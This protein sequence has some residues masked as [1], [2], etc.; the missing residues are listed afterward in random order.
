MKT[1]RTKMIAGLAIALFLSIAVIG[2]VVLSGG[3][4]TP[5]KDVPDGEWIGILNSATSVRTSYLDNKILTIDSSMEHSPLVTVSASSAAVRKMGSGMAY[6]P[7]IITDEEDDA[8]DRY[9]SLSE[10][11]P[12][13]IGANDPPLDTIN[14]AR[15][16]FQVADVIMVY[17]TY[18]EGLKG[19]ALAS[20]YGI[21]MIYA[22]EETSE[23]GELME[24]LEVKYAISIGEAPILSVPTMGLDTGEGPC[25]NEF[26]LMCLGSKGDSTDYV[27]VTNPKDIENNWGRPDQ[28]PT[29]GVSMASAQLIAYR[30]ALSFFVKGYNSSELSVNFDDPE[31]FNQMGASVEVS[32]GY[33]F[34]IKENMIHAW[35]LSQE[36]EAFDLKFLG[37]VGDPIGVP[38]HYEYFDPAETGV[39]LSNTRFIAS[40]YYFSDLEGDEKQEI[41]Y[42]RIVGRTLTD[43]SLL[44]ARTLGFDEYSESQ[45]ERGN[46][47]D[48][49][50]FDTLSPDWKDNAG[51]FIGT[52][53]PFPLP[54]ALKHM[55]KYHY[56]VLGD[57]GM[58]VT[59]EESMRL[60]DVT[61]DM[62]MDK[63][64]Y[65]MYCGHGLQSAWYS[66]RADNIDARFVSTQELKPGFTAVMA[67]L[68]GR[69]DNLEDNK[70]DMISMSFI[71]A[72]LNG[73]IGAS[74]L[75]YGLFAIGDG[76]QGLLLDTGALY[77]VDC[78]TDHFVNEDLTIG[79]LLMV[80]RNDLIDKW[81][82]DGNSNESQEAITTTW[83]YLL[84]G[85]PAWN[86]A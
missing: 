82:L 6:T 76:E 85:D 35:N 30:S 14:I 71:H 64:N 26:F 59:S 37:I 22:T 25:H 17:S 11:E 9:L 18:Q 58:F 2:I 5:G 13:K 38:F 83:E 19:V 29:R 46:D 73:Y 21:P 56:D 84:Y 33:A 39:T 77:L 66:N 15:Q 62:V 41:S 43:T 74:R 80:S 16:N 68:T 10:R 70:E 23:L 34:D 61:A 75:A 48:Q 60:N 28:I 36:N 27:V 69:I 20:Y 78:I 50:I 24:E 67:C 40:D 44:L 53:K 52:S 65:L 47:L 32:N 8:F 7:I 86:P 45:F 72:G 51:V 42:G 1:I 79:E 57:G 49:R 4:D 31:N 3:D 54:G 12:I 63:M 55:K 81:G